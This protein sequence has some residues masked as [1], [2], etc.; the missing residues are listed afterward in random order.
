[1]TYIS[2]FSLNQPK[3]LN[4]KAYLARATFNNCTACLMKVLLFIIDMM[5]LYMFVKF[6]ESC[7]EKFKVLCEDKRASMPID[8]GPVAAPKYAY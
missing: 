2:L 1:M 7:D 4:S 6:Q 3:D 8:T 5:M